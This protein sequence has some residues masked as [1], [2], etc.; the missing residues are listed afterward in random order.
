MP[1][2]SDR[3]TAAVRGLVG[4]AAALATGGL[5]SG[6]AT[7]QQ[8]AARLRLNADRIRA[9]Q[10]STRVTVAGRTV[11]VTGVATVAAGARTAFVVTVRNR[12]ATAVSDLPISVG[13]RR[14]RR[15]VYA[16]AS[17]DGGYFSAHLP[18]IG[19]GRAFTWVYVA[20]RR[21]PPG[22]RAFAI[23]GAA[24]SVPAQTVARP[25]VIDAA[26][27][28]IRRSVLRVALRNRS[29][30]AQLQLPV[31]AFAISGHRDRVVA[32]GTATINQLPGGS[33]AT[34]RLHLLGRV[35]H[36]VVRLEAPPTILR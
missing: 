31:Y 9:G 25:P 17:A 34:L 13:Y 14:G 11:A 6:C 22:A 26:D 16:N 33:R 32:A 23:V 28:A 8:Q 36:A 30:V 24:P 1:S 3:A 4:A 10:T 15:R 29:S 5:L 12:R 7:T 21:L 2:D 27:G 18:A 19:P 20:A 35:D